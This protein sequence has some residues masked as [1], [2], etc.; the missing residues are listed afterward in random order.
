MLK[1]PSTNSQQAGERRLFLWAPE[2]DHMNLYIFIMNRK[3]DPGSHWPASFTSVP[4]NIMELLQ[5]RLKY[6]EV[7][8][9]NQHSFTKGKSWLISLMAFYDGVAASADKGKVTDAIYL[10]F[11]R[12][13]DTVH[14]NILFSILE[15]EGFDGWTIRWLRKWLSDHIQRVVVIGSESY[16][17]QW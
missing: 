8:G 14:H 13:F 6:I 7:V 4:G 15:R 10:D 17:H 16:G 9:D 3:Y 11:C 12:A 2:F 1:Q 5:F